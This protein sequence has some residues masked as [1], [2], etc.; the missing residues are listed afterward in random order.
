MSENYNDYT[1]EQLEEIINELRRR[2]NNEKY[3]LYFDRKATPEEVVEQTKIEIPILKRNGTM[4]FIKGVQTHILI[5][6]DNFHALS[7]LNLINDQKGLVDVIYI[8][9][10]YNTG[11]QD[12][13]YNDKFIDQE[14]GYRHT[15]WLNFMEK[16]LKLARELLTDNGVIFISI[17]DNE[18][19]Q[20]KLLCDSIFGERNRITTFI[21][22]KT[23]HFGRQKINF[24]SNSEYIL[25]YAKKLV[26][27]KIKELLVESINSS[28]LDAPLYNASNPTKTLTF[29][30]GSTLINLPDGEYYKTTNELYFLESP[31]IVKNKTN[32]NPLI[33][34]FRSRWSN[35]TVQRE[36]QKG[37]TFWVK[38]EA[39]AIRTIYH[40]GKTSKTS[41][42][43]IIFTNSNNPLVSQSRFKIKVGVNEEASKELSKIVNQ[44]SF[45][46]PK[47]VSL[48]KYLLSMI[49][50]PEA[51]SFNDSFTCLDF[52]AGSGTTA[53]AVLEL[54]KEDGGS[55]KFILCTNNEGNIMSEVCYPRIQTVITGKRQDGSQYSDGIPANMISFKIDFVKNSS[56][57][58]QVKFNLVQEVDSLLC[59]AEDSFFEVEQK[60][61]Y[62]IYSNSEGTK[63][64]VIFRDFYDKKEFQ[65][66]KLFFETNKDKC[67]T[68]YQF[69]T[70]NTVDE[71]VFKPLINVV[72]KPIPNKIYEI[73]KLI[74]DDIK[75]EY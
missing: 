54:N 9:P 70:D 25:C 57:K 55:R 71:N 67:I 10:P 61:K 41:P 43:Q 75:R 74:V 17:D 62:G 27:S 20:L 23:Q 46:Y 47:P 56:S 5:E 38:T 45:T 53:Q 30:I 72:V 16:R 12:F 18:Q 48:I 33:L 15:K 4:D 59:I 29:P 11:N 22:E 34:T 19:A 69:S 52:F 7:A 31:V 49:Y 24:Y 1:K 14:D 40:E 2:L 36:F 50:D 28:L 21:W 60:D 65:K 3:G 37:T 6:G 66:L 13:S 8:D 44:N 42:K 63:L 39:F 26:D 32:I 51:D 73:Y 58:D 64:T 35:D 68:F